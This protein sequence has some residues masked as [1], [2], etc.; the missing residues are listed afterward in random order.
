[1]PNS[2]KTI[3][4]LK[5]RIRATNLSYRKQKSQQDTQIFINNKKLSELQNQLRTLNKDLKEK[6]KKISALRLNLSKDGENI[7]IREIKGPLLKELK[8]N[9]A[10]NN[11]LNNKLIE[12]NPEDVFK[13]LSS[14]LATVEGTKSKQKQWAENFYN[15]LSLNNSANINHY[16][17]NRNKIL[18]LINDMNKFHLNKKDLLFTIDKIL[19]DERS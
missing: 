10:A 13:R 17:N 15:E 18:Y 14:F 16:Y 19:K 4:L 6:E 12:K 11:D 3:F 8:I 9:E 5:E 2:N 7:L 1:M